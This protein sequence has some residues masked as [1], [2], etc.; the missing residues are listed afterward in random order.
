MQGILQSLQYDPDCHLVTIDSTGKWSPFQTNSNLDKRLHSNDTGYDVMQ[1]HL[2][3]VK[4]EPG[5]DPRVTPNISYPQPSP[6]MNGGGRGKVKQPGKLLSA[7]SV[8]Q[9]KTNYDTMGRYN[10]EAPPCE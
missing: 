3:N 5:Y 8:K 2:M 6:V 7:L 4:S 9:E 10:C 1:P